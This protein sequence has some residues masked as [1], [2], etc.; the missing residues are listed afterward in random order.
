MACPGP[1]MYGPIDTTPAQEVTCCRDNVQLTARARDSSPPA[2]ERT[3][4]SVVPHHAF[5]G[6]QTSPT[7]YLVPHRCGN[8]CHELRDVSQPRSMQHLLQGRHLRVDD[9]DS[10]RGVKVQ[11]RR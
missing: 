2:R 10:M 6:V 11:D 9:G 4:V 5:R 3:H 1:R 8:A 7:H